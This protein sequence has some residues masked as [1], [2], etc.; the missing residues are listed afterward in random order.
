MQEVKALT[1]TLTETF[2]A[3]SEARPL[4]RRLFL[5]LWLIALTGAGAA[6]VSRREILV[7]RLTAPPSP[8]ASENAALAAQGAD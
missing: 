7:D 4:S 2:G 3:R 6:F 8:A 5:A 1:A